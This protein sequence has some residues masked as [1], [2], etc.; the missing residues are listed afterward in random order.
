MDEKRQLYLVLYSGLRDTINGSK[1]GGNSSTLLEADLKQTTGHT[2]IS[3]PGLP[4]GYIRDT[5][6]RSCSLKSR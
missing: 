2:R 6:S 1:D 4:M 5:G 3:V